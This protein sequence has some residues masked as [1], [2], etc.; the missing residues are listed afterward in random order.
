[1][2]GPASADVSCRVAWGDDAPA[3]AAVQVRAWRAS[4][5]GILPPDLL[6]SMSVD[7]LAEHWRTSLTRP[8]DARN[9]VLV[10]LER[11]LVTG[12][13]LTGPAADPDCD[14]LADGEVTDLTVDPHK[15]GQ[16]HGSRLVQA[17]VDTLRAD[18]FTRAVTWLAAQDDAA[19]S[20]LTEAGWAPD[21]AHRTLDLTGDGTVQVK[22]VRLHTAL[23]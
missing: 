16:G 11:N 21:G 1:M 17:V 10:A 19:R 3:I 20:F 13:A 4:Y 7:E 9:R 2:T 15:R 5:A 8:P 23:G 22:Q 14:P 6:D 18:R 12:F